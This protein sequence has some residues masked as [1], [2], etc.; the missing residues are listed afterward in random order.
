MSNKQKYIEVID[1]K[2]AQLRKAKEGILAIPES[3]FDD[4]VETVFSDLVKDIEKPI[5]INKPL[6]N[7]NYAA[8]TIITSDNGYG[9]NKQ[10]VI[11]A[12]LDFNRPVKKSELVRYFESKGYVDP[13]QV[14]TNAIVALK[15]DGKIKGYK[16]N[17][18]RFKGL[19]WTLKKWWE[20]GELKPEYNKLPPSLEE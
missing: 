18:V 1:G 6:P 3:I 7:S 12:L 13:T 20:N 10:T 14:I 5:T 15:N 17:G 8:T 19:L 11:E 16:P 4:I 9:R 2:I